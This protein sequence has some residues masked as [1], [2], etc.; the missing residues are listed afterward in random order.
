M[1]M[2]PQELNSGINAIGKYDPKYHLERSKRR[3]RVVSSFIIS[4]KQDS[5]G[6]PKP[7]K[8]CGRTYLHFQMQFD[9]LESESKVINLS[10]ASRKRWRQS[11]IKSEIEKCELVCIGCHRLRTHSRFKHIPNPRVWKPTGI[12]HSCKRCS[13]YLDTGFFYKSEGRIAWCY[14]C[15]HERRVVKRIKRQNYINGFKVKPC[16][17][18]GESFQPLLMDFDHIDPTVKSFSISHGI[19][20]NVNLNRLQEEMSKCRLLCVW[21]HVLVTHQGI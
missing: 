13:N 2:E 12:F 5:N 18:C 15:D 14:D 16:C 19:R 4:L 17:L 1:K 11:R 6:K 7:C 20:L 9:H 10:K 8:D 3:T 21:C